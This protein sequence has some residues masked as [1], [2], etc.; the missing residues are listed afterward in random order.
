[1]II[2]FG[3]LCLTHINIY[4]GSYD[5]FLPLDATY[6]SAS[7]RVISLL[8]VTRGLLHFISVGHRD[9]ELTY[10]DARRPE[11]RTSIVLEVNSVYRQALLTNHPMSIKKPDITSSGTL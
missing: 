6:T 8:T 2:G 1:M 10:P 9:Y 5:F 3:F 4:G 11:S 7:S